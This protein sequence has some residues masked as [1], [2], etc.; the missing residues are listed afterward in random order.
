MRTSTTTDQRQVVSKVFAFCF[1]FLL[2]NNLI[3]FRVVFQKC[4]NKLSQIHPVDCIKEVVPILSWLPK[5]PVKQYLSGDLISGLTVAVMH[6]PQGIGYALLGH[7]P[8]IVGIYMAFFPVLMYFLFGTSRHNS[9]G[10]FAVICIMVGKS[11]LRLG[12][13]EDHPPANSTVA[14]GVTNP[15]ALIASAAT[16]E[17]IEVATALCF[18]VG[19]WQL[20]MYV[21]RLGAVSSL[22]SET[23][24]S[25]F[26]TGA[27]IHVLTSQVKDLFGLRLTPIT[28]YFEVILVSLS[29]PTL[30]DC[31]FNSNVNFSLD[32]QANH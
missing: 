2:L 5:Y 1:F 21:M 16:Y 6:I 19:I 25:G 17:P 4:S 3:F 13:H 18:V 20:V 23:L 12:T 27:A 22:L 7:V 15:A 32:L 28:G 8:P 14:D 24:V 10:T 9:M 26:T 29:A 30:Y 31:S 11:V